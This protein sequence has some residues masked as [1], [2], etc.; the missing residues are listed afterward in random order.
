MVGNLTTPH[1]LSF[2]DKDDVSLNHPRNYL[3]HIEVLI[4]KHQVKHV[5]I[6][7]GASLNI[8]T[9]TLICA[10]GFSKNAMDPKR[11]ITIKDYDDEGISFE[12]LVVLPIKVGPI[13][14]DT[15]CQVLDIGLSYN[16]LLGRPWIHEMKAVQ[17]KYH[18]FLKY[19]YNG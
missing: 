4:Y 6:D 7:G 19:P 2:S 17:S 3:L 9:L 18:Q 5:L 1:Y 11:E 12:G 16:I 13:Q 10:L 15:I 8:W 14:K